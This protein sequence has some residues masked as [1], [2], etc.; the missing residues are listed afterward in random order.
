[1]KKVLGLDLGTASI[2]WALVSEA[3]NE[4]E[5][6]SITKLGVRI[7]QFDNFVSTDTGKESK[8]PEKDFISGKGISP[9]AGRTQKRAARR[10]LQRFKL[11]KENLI[12]ILKE[13]RF[14]ANDTVLS[15]NGNKTTFETY[16]LRAKAATE[17][18][19]LEQFARILLMI[20]KKRGYKSSRKAKSQDEGS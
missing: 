2:G 17:E 9:N 3:E 5:K 19:T 7:I 11:R 8:E 6:S 14:I 16:R 12:E 1:M 13:N 4:L 15:E 18:V 20:N 10:N